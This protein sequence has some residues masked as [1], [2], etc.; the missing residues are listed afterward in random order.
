MY[1][2]NN[3]ES[4]ARNSPSNPSKPSSTQIC[5]YLLNEETCLKASKSQTSAFCNVM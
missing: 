5:Q 1:N 3:K 2:N 4:L